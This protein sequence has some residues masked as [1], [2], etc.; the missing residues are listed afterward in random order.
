MRRVGWGFFVVLVGGLMS[1]VAAA[2][3]VRAGDVTLSADTLSVAEGGTIQGFVTFHGKTGG[4]VRARVVA[5]RDESTAVFRERSGPSNMDYDV[6]P[7]FL[8]ES[9]YVLVEHRGS[10][11]GGRIGF[12]LLVNDDDLLEDAE[13]LTLRVQNIQNIGTEDTGQSFWGAHRTENRL[14]YTIPGN[15]GTEASLRD[16]STT[17]ETPATEGETVNAIV[18]IHGA[19]R[20]FSSVVEFAI[21][22]TVT[23]ADYEVI[24]RELAPVLRFDPNTEMGSIQLYS[25]Q[26]ARGIPIRLL[27]DGVSDDD[28]TLV[29]TLTG[30]PSYEFSATPQ[31]FRITD[32]SD[33]APVLDPATQ[34]D[35]TYTTG[36]PIAN[37]VLPA[38]TGGNG[39][40]TYTLAPAIATAIPGLA[41]DADTRVVS[42]TPT[43][44][45]A[46]VTLTYTA[47]DNDATTT[48]ADTDT[49]TFSI[50][51]MVPPAV[52]VT[53]AV[54]ISTTTLAVDEGGD[55][56]SATYTVV[57]T[58]DP[59][60]AV[61]I[62]PSV[63]PTGHNLTLTPS[64]ALEF[65]SSTW[66][67]AQAISV[68]AATDTDAIDD[69]ATISH[70]VSGYG[71]VTA[72]DVLVQV[73]D[74]DANDTA[75]VFDPA[76][77]PDQVYTVNVPI[78][79]LVLP[80]ATGGNGGKT[81]A[82]ATTA[83]PGLA[84]DPDTR[85]LSGTPTA[86]A[87]AVVLNYRAADADANL[88]NDDAARLTFRVTVLAAP[89]VL[90]SPPSLTVNEGGRPGIYTAVLTAA[91]PSGENVIIAA[92]VDLRD[93]LTISPSPPELTFDSGNWNVP[94]A[95]T[96]TAIAD[97]S[98]DDERVIVTHTAT[99]GGIDPGLSDVSIARLTVTLRVRDL[100]AGVT[101]TPPTLAVNQESTERYTV[102]LNAAPTGG[103][104]VMI[105]PIS[106]DTSV[107]TVSAPLVFSAANWETPQR[108][109][110]RGVS[111]GTAR[112]THAVTHG[113]NYNGVPAG[114]VA[115]TV[116][117]TVTDHAAD[118]L[119][120]VILPE[121]TRAMSDRQ[122]GAIARRV[123]QARSGA[124]GIDSPGGYSVAAWAAEAMR[125]GA[126]NGNEFDGKALLGASDFVLPLG[127]ADGGGMLD[128]G[129]AMWGGGEFL[130]LGGKSGN[131]E[132]DGDLL[133]VNA[134][135][136]GKL[137]SDLLA[138]LMLSWNE[139]RVGYIDDTTD[140]RERGDYDLDM[141]SVH[142]YIGTSMMDGRLDWWATLGFGSG[143]LEIRNK[144][145]NTSVTSDVTLQMLGVG[146]NSRLLARGDGELR[147]RAEA[148]TTRTE[149]EGSKS[150]NRRLSELKADAR[151][152]RVALQARK[153]GVTVGG[154][155]LEP[156][157]ELGYRYDGG[158]GETG[159]GIE[160]GGALR[161]INTERG[162]TLEGYTRALMSHSGD[163][164]EIGL[165]G[166]MRLAQGADGQGL[167][168]SLT[169]GYG[170]AG[171]AYG[172]GAE[173]IW[174]NGLSDDT[175]TD[176]QAHLNARVGYGL[177]ATAF[178]LTPYGEMA[179]GEEVQNYRLGL[180]WGLG[181]LFDLNLVG[182]R[183][184]SDSVGV[185]HA[186]WLK[187]EM[188]F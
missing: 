162:L 154:G 67:I 113:G 176:L 170:S 87:D 98:F 25:G 144:T 38:A 184:E 118:A 125:A 61:T 89:V 124:G 188:R 15:D 18:D 116:S 104:N 145:N 73:A 91:P 88:A 95:F 43:A 23:T 169:P 33:T 39:D 47:A 134:G 62:T 60:G 178:M 29:V 70:A 100:P 22:G 175:E 82:L 153:A 79:D 128:A 99:G 5:L 143:D 156:S 51:V 75:P 137:Q 66:N 16:A 177:P 123:G 122:I 140:T 10:G 50:T 148:F 65:T 14:T 63:A 64:G 2:Q 19:H 132:W 168:L 150:S 181:A 136:D 26:N 142:P 20:P 59:G 110:V 84:F 21:S 152:V 58:T 3:T 179:L 151:R 173:E 81:Y 28:E 174:Q 117:E 94:Q 129:A 34:P 24:T 108:V 172:G 185:E 52:V 30:H 41:F 48:A 121:V 8:R 186:I 55:S 44:A 120:R 13:T 139:A 7:A 159:G 101:I 86:V 71:S 54:T 17:M 92:V 97:A 68:A 119:N 1:G 130:Q 53:P 77:Q 114:A 36:T 57:L 131:I 40:I 107:A 158:D 45:T 78:D 112:I 133:S 167:S 149:V 127:A 31:T 103:G 49:L 74:S 76:T 155:L 93:P 90:L 32:A 141:V 157:M 147:L 183:E 96:V 6:A 164:D 4:T 135:I 126:N 109:E 111:G 42:G 83:V 27:N 37:L 106:G 138:G 105:R 46:A 80:V 85:T 165:G 166:H 180:S 171:K 182:E 163:Y 102:T 11:D 72:A 9:A 35:Q 56:A 187:G 12:T 146:G 161:Y 115:V 160:V 69:I